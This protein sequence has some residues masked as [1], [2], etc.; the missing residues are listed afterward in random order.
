MTEILSEAA[1]FDL[2]HDIF[3]IT[4]FTRI[5]NAARSADN[6]IDPA[7]RQDRQC[8]NHQLVV[9]VPV[10]LIGQIKVFHR[11]TVM[12]DNFKR[13]GS[14]KLSRWLGRETNYGDLIS[15]PRIVLLIVA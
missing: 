11:Q 14:Q 8:I 10:E 9:L 1:P 15:R 2:P 13:Y 5:G 7:L 12:L 4:L 3:E 6:N